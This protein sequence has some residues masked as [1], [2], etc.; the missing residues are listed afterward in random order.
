M[1]IPIANTILGLILMH[2]LSMTMWRALLN[3]TIPSLN[4]RSSS[5]AG[6]ILPRF[7][8]QLTNTLPP[9]ELSTTPV[10]ATMSTSTTTTQSPSQLVSSLMA[11]SP[12]MQPVIHVHPY[13]APQL[14]QTPQMVLMSANPLDHRQLK[15]DQLA[16]VYQTSQNRPIIVQPQTVL[17]LRPTLAAQASTLNPIRIR[18]DPKTPTRVSQPS[19]LLPSLGDRKQST[20]T[21]KKHVSVNLTKSEELHIKQASKLDQIE[22]ESEEIV[23]MMLNSK[24]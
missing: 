8:L 19:G 21:E 1:T 7:N 22:R 23:D 6:M 15:L 18:P 2:G 5:S 17:R 14:V 11:S 16:S 10:P 9:V 3:S 13:P 20:T 4:V 24:G 12:F